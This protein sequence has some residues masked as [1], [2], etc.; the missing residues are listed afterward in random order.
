VLIDEVGRGTA[1]A[2]GLALATSIAHWLIDTSKCRTVF[3]THFHELTSLPQYS[4]RVF[5]L[6]V[7]IVETRSRIEF[8]H[9]I[10]YE[11][12]K[13]SYGIHVARLAG[14]PDAL[15]QEASR[16]LTEG[17]P[18][19]SGLDSDQGA[20]SEQLRDAC[21][22]SLDSARIPIDLYDLLIKIKSLKPENLTPLQAL[23]LIYEFTAAASKTDF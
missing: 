4:D 3:A 23:E 10:E 21:N 15:I 18:M 19:L 16:L 8:T 11:V 17:M 12:S 5:C 6:S 20:V 9:R 14:V 7:G 22:S 2:D 1:T 13:K